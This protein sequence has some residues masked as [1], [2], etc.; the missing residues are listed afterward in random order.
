MSSNDSNSDQPQEVHFTGEEKV[1][2]RTTPA[3]DLG[4]LTLLAYLL[5]A[6]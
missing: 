2:E 1:G 4:A 6:R 3:K 5:L